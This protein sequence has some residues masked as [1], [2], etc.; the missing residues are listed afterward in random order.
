MTAI[1]RHRTP[2]LA[3]LFG[4][5]LLAGCQQKKENSLPPATGD[6]AP[7]PP[8]IPQLSELAREN[9]GEVASGGE[10]VGTGSLHPLHKAE[11][12]PKETG[13]LTEIAVE[14]GDRVKKGQLLFK[15]DAVQAQLAVAQA[16]AQQGAAR[17]QLDSAKL[18]FE[19]TKALRERGSIAEDA[20]DQARSRLDAAQ[21]AVE[22]AEAAMGLAQ[23][24]ATNMVVHSPID[25]IVT[26]KRMNVGETATLMPPS[27]VL[28]VQNIDQLELRVLLPESALKTVR[29]GSEL[30]VSF[31]AV[32]ETR[33]VKVKRIAPTVDVRTR[34][35]EIVAAVDNPDHRLKAGML[36]EV[37][38]GERAGEGSAAA[39]ETA[40][41]SASGGKERAPTAQAE[42]TRPEDKPKRASGS[43][44]P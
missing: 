13:L 9:P 28:V 27:I 44:T 42:R 20:L 3:L 8:H 29:E 41:H 19:R 30:T 37:Q 33:R 36:A 43:A 15:L 18:D 34:T 22:Q 17:V 25:G 23:R 7:P 12:G 6:K 16:K 14:E 21:S 4:L 26:D 40:A 10:R 1:A 32:D 5:A 35:I 2:I 31:P 24:H 11:L 38:Y 39:D